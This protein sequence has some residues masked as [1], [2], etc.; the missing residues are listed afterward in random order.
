MQNRLCRHK[1]LKKNPGNYAVNSAMSLSLESGNLGL[2][3]RKFPVF[4]LYFD[5]I[6]PVLSL[7]EIFFVIFP[8]C[9][10][11]WGPC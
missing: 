9:P 11:Q 10:S 6:F 8:V 1:V 3:H 5:N 4:S 7:A 2:K